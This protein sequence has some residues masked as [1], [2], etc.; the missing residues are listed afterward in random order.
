MTTLISKN[1]FLTALGCPTQMWFDRRGS[2]RALTASEELRI[3]EGQQIGEMARAQFAEGVLVTEKDPRTAAEKTATLMADHSVSVIFEAAF[4]AESFVTRVDVL[5]RRENG[6]MLIEVKS[7]RHKDEKISG[8]HIDDMAYTTMVVTM[9][10]VRVT[11]VELMRLSD[12]WR[13]TGGAQFKKAD[14]TAAVQERVEQ[15]RQQTRGVL[16]NVFSEER[17]TPRLLTSCKNCEYFAS[18]CL[19]KGIEY[20]IVEIPRISE[21]KVDELVALNVI[22][23][24]DIPPAFELTP[25]Q[26]QMVLTI[27]SGEMQADGVKLTKLLSKLSWP[28]YYLDFET[29]MSALPLWDGIAPFEQVLTQY[30][31]HKCSSLMSEPEHFEYLAPL[32]HDAR[33][34]LAE[35]L[36]RDLGS[37]GSIVVYSSFEKTQ[38]TTLSQLF[39]DLAPQLL[40]LCERLFDLEVVFKQAV[41]HPGFRGKTSIKVTLPTLVPEMSYKNLLIGGGDSAVAAFVRMVRGWCSSEEVAQ[42]REALLAYCKQDTLAMVKLHRVVAALY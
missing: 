4:I 12:E 25:T 1:T 29:A 33:R 20:P 39:P 30:S 37:T 2:T 3:I 31:I 35:Q 24:R 13:G 42:L 23:V 7:A 36:I 9:A 6:W 16:L 11:A 28:C 15:F 32:T 27:S 8:E 14:A 38:I 41:S 18:Q 19:G 17:P 34:E 10:G 40:P 22:D 5:I 26:R 21:Q